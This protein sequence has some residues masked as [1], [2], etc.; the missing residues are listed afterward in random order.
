MEDLYK[1]RHDANVACAKEDIF[2]PGLKLSE[3]L[4]WF[5]V[6][7]PRLAWFVDPVRWWFE[8]RGL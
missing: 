7:Y 5:V 1:W 6:V 2:K 3:R 8:R 4:Y